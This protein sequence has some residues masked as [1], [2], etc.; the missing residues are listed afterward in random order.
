MELQ[1]TAVSH[2]PT[3]LAMMQPVLGADRFVFCALPAGGWTE[4]AALDP[5]AVVRE[6]EALTVVVSLAVAEAHGLATEPAMRRITLGV[7]SDLEAVGLTA[8][9]TTALAEV[10]I[11]ANVVAGYY[12]DHIFVPDRQ[13]KEAMRALS[14]LQARSVQGMTA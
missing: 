5:V 10:G 11:S 3:L 14:A 2:L 6:V 8:A 9:F 1:M 12:H 13:A 7:H 4:V